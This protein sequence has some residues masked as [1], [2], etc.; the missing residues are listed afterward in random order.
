MYYTDRAKEY[1]KMTFSLDF[2]KEVHKGM[3]PFYHLIKMLIFLISDVVQVVM[4]TF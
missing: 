2:A 1:S 4:Q 3:K